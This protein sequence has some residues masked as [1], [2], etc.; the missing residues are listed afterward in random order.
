ME[1]LQYT[2]NVK[3]GE[4]AEILAALLFDENFEGVEE[5]KDQLIAY[6]AAS[7][8]HQLSSLTQE[9]CY[10][11]NIVFESKIIEDSNWNAQWESDFKPVL[12]GN[13]CF[14]GAQHHQA[15]S[16]IKHHIIIQPQMSFGTGHHPTTFLMVQAM[17]Q[18]KD[19][20][21]KVLDFGSGTGVLA[22]LAEQM[23]SKNILAIDNDPNAYD[24]IKTNIQLNNCKHIAYKLGD[25][26]QSE[27]QCFEIILANVTRNV[28]SERLQH[29]SNALN[30]K[31]KLYC[32]GFFKHDIAFFE[33]L[34][35]SNSNLNLTI[36]SNQSKDDW[37]CILFT[38]K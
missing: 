30:P 7:E 27:N 35:A 13:E 23:G 12:V 10:A 17:L 11:H 15:P 9:F 8:N 20:N 21:K 26:E 4:N 32:S 5:Q 18:Q 1:Y 2:F 29:L 24:N 22:I 14:I 38:K 34:I 3:R 28:V 25:I 16:Q 31:G 6:I 36:E 33:E 37:A 19:W